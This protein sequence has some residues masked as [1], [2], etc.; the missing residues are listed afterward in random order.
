ML[1]ANKIRP[2]G[3]ASWKKLRSSAVSAGP[4]QPRIA[5][6]G[7][8]LGDNQAPH[9]TGLQVTASDLCQ[10]SIRQR[11]CLNAM[12]DALI[13]D[14]HLLDEEL[15]AT[16]NILVLAAETDPFTLSS[17]VTAHGCSA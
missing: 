11:A 15:Q 13:A 12:V 2:N 1:R 7:G 6:A 8:L 3:L 5:A 10:N 16:Q 4:E 14:I 17:R 9:A